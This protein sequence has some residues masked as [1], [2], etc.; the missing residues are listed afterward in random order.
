MSG[1]T[2]SALTRITLSR[3]QHSYFRWGQTH[4]IWALGGRVQR[5]A[6]FIIFVEGLHLPGN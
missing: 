2:Y 1:E 4:F 6:G 5:P 3:L